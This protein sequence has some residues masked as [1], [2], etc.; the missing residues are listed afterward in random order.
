MKLQ[1]KAFWRDSRLLFPG[2]V[3]ALAMGCQMLSVRHQAF[4]GFIYGKCTGQK[5]NKI[6]AE[7]TVAFNSPCNEISEVKCPL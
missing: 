3:S 6:Q 4:P 1:F 5:K 7:F 2:W